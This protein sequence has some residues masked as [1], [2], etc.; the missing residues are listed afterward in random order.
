MVSLIL[1]PTKARCD[2][3]KN[4]AAFYDFFTKLFRT[5]PALLCMIQYRAA[6]HERFNDNIPRVYLGP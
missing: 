5:R 6:P 3:A 2:Q 4:T 1:S